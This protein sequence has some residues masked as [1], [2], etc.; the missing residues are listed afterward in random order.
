LTPIHVRLSAKIFDM[1]GDKVT[2]IGYASAPGSPPTASQA[3]VP[4]R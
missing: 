4:V 2:D 1:A 3:Q